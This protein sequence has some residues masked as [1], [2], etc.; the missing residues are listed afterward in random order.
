MAKFL[1]ETA[2]DELSELG[3]NSI[4]ILAKEDGFDSK[5]TSR[6]LVIGLGGMGLKTMIR[7]KRELNERVGVIDGSILRSEGCHRYRRKT[8]FCSLGHGQHGRTHRT[9]CGISVYR[10]GRN[11]CGMGRLQQLRYHNKSICYVYKP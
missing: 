4:G 11:G 6:V 3:T 9:L 8:G 7:L 2:L 10:R 1:S 5:H